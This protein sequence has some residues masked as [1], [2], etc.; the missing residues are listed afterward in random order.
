MR[1]RSSTLRAI[2]STGNIGSVPMT[3]R[4]LL[5]PLSVAIS[6]VANVSSRQARPKRRASSVAGLVGARPCRPGW[7]SVRLST[8]SRSRAARVSDEAEMPSLRAAVSIEACSATA[9]RARTWVAVI[10]A[11]IGLRRLVV[12]KRGTD[13]RRN[14]ASLHLGEHAIGAGQI[15]AAIPVR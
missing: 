13:A 3:T 9:I 1:S 5:T 10:L 12:G 4:E 14:Q 2:R 8:A 15:G 6:S 7:N 11:R